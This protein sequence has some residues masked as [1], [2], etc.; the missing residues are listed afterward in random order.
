[1][2]PGKV[3]LGVLA[4]VAAGAVLGV[5]FAPARGAATRKRGSE[6]AADCL[7][8]VKDQL[9]DAADVIASKIGSAKAQATDVTR[10]AK[11]AID[12]T[13]T[14]LRRARK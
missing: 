6:M 13:T 7:D 12:S 4:G 2:S 3:V 10:R 5:L 14:E 1:M 8:D 9:H 11:D